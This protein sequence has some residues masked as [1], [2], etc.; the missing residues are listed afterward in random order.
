MAFEIVC[1]NN[2]CKIEKLIILN[3]NDI[4]KLNFLQLKVYK[5]LLSN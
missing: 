2:Y 3:K 1:F 4:F 5:E